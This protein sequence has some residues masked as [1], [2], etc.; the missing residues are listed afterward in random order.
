MEKTKMNPMMWLQIG[1]ELKDFKNYS[2]RN[3][4]NEICINTNVII[5]IEMNI[6]ASM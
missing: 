6:N 1:C 5:D 3:E 4:F 2:Y